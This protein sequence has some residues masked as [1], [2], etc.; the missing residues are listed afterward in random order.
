MF[1]VATIIVEMM[2]V[3]MLL[4]LFE[5]NLPLGFLITTGFFV[6]S[7]YFSC[8]VVLVDRY[9]VYQPARVHTGESLH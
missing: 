5:V 7:R 8:I 3:V 2:D 6:S 9:D 1:V 4:F